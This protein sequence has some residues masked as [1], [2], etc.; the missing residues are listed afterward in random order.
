MAVIKICKEYYLME[1]DGKKVAVLRR[2]TPITSRWFAS[3]GTE[4]TSTDH[5]EQIMSQFDEDHKLDIAVLYDIVNEMDAVKFVD[6]STEDNPGRKAIVLENH[7]SI[8]GKPTEGDAENLI[9]M[10]KLNKVDVGTSGYEINLNGSAERPTYNYDEELALKKDVDNSIISISSFPLRSLQDEIYEK[11][12]I[13]GWFGVE[14]E[15]VLK[16]KIANEGMMYI[17][18]GETQSGNPHYYRMP[19][20]YIAFES[21]TQIKMIFVGLNTENNVPSKY[22]VVI[23]I[24]G[25]IVSGNSNV[26]MTVSETA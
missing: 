23:N 7:D 26:S 13:L 10:S 18:Y 1:I 15:S 21:D 19:V 3:D 24:D 11:Q 4:Y 25:T 8:L 12:T 20:H 22:E 17:K 2:F 16:D 6:I 14:D 9:M 5:I